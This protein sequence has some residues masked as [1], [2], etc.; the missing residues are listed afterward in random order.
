MLK[1]AYHVSHAGHLK[2]NIVCHVPRLL[3]FETDQEFWL[4]LGLEATHLSHKRLL[5]VLKQKRSMLLILKNLFS[6]SSKGFREKKKYIY[7]IQNCV[8]KLITYINNLCQKINV[9][10]LYHIINIVIECL[11]NTSFFF[12]SVFPILL[13][14][15][16][17]HKWAYLFLLYLSNAEDSFI[18]FR[19][20]FVTN[21]VSYLFLKLI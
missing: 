19:I 21:H 3:A 9:C 1:R 20:S 12:C 11:W 7:I 14:H 2:I 4:N 5:H 8:L 17:H 18:S 16:T 10:E 6:D 15:E 13:H